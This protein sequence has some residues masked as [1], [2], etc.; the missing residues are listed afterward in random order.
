M[1]Q[2]RE[3]INGETFKCSTKEEH[4]ESEGIDQD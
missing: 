4:E 2:K 1:K 3:K